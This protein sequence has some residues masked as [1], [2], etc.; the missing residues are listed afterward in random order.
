MGNE[1]Y[2]QMKFYL[3][4]KQLPVREKLH[5]ILHIRSLGTVKG[6]VQ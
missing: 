1:C 6:E 3:F 2:K 4:D 5:L